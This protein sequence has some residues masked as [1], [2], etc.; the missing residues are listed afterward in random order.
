LTSPAF[1]DLD[2]GMQ[3]AS[4]FERAQM[5]APVSLALEVDA[6]APAEVVWQHLVRADRWRQ[7][8][9]G[10][11][12]AHV[13]RMGPAQ[14]PHLSPVIKAVGDRLDWRVDGIR[15][16]S[17]L[18]EV[19]PPLRLEWTLQTLGARGALRW[20]L[21]PA[22]SHGCRVRL[23]EWWT[24]IPVRLLRR[25]LRRTLRVSRT[26]WLE[27]L[28]AQIQASPPPDALPELE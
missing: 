7:W 6:L 13:R 24:G 4:P 14:P 21:D 1:P 28:L 9:R 12:T 16:R 5:A 2:L 19:T 17:V 3:E 8:Y 10:I 22:R 25:T 15:I 23:E 26:A 11:D 18:T 20:T 27:G